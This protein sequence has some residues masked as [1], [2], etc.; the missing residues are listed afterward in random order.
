MLK[1]FAVL[2]ISR[3]FCFPKTIGVGQEASKRNVRF[4]NSQIRLKIPEGKNPEKILPV[5]PYEKG[6]SY[7]KGI[8]KL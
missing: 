6:K 2:S 1:N 4:E 3:Q 5:H 8:G 7:Y